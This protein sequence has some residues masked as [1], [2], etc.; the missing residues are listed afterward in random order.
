VTLAV[1]LDCVDAPLTES[2]NSRMP[3]PSERPISGSRLAP[4]TSKMNT[5]KKAMW[6]GLSS[7]IYQSLRL[8]QGNWIIFLLFA[9][10]V[11][12]AALDGWSKRSPH[13]LRGYQKDHQ[14][15]RRS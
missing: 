14:R 8:L 3:V 4:N 5:T 12:V 10:L 11:P 13:E 9:L 15:K 6:I 7:P 2:L 1:K